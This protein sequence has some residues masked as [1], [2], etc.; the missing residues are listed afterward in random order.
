MFD[1]DIRRS[2]RLPQTSLVVRK[3]VRPTLDL[4]TP[5][6]RLNHRLNQL[7]LAA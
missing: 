1:L 2:Q 6:H 4:D 3:N 7:L 5:G